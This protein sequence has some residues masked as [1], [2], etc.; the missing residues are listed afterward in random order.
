MKRSAFVRKLPERHQTDPDRIRVTPSVRPEFRMGAPVAAPAAPVEKEGALQSEAY[1]RLV[2][3]MP[4]A[5][6]GRAAPSQHCHADA[7]KGMGIKTDTRRSF[8][9]CG[10]HGD[11]PG[12]H[13]LLG[14]SGRIPREERR[15]LEERYG[16]ETRAAIRAAG[17][18]PSTLPEW[19]S[20][21][22]VK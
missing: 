18:W 15:A 4:C 19:A 16:R 9:G 22:E 13:W 20:D 12:C 2:R 14:T 3:L 11:D 6:C 8:P 10:P 1:A 7:G 17:Q 5:H 21:G